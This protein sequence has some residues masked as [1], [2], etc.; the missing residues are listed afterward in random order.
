MACGTPPSEALQA[1]L[2]PGPSAVQRRSF[3][4]FVTVAPVEGFSCTET[5]CERREPRERAP[6]RE[7]LTVTVPDFP[8][9]T[10]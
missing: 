10:R 2:Y 9:A 7:G 1:W 8:A 6:R 5:V 3:S 4:D